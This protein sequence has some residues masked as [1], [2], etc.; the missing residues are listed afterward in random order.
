MKAK[1]IETIN[2][3]NSSLI[4]HSQF[5][6]F[7]HLNQVRKEMVDVNNVAVDLKSLQIETNDK[8]SLSSIQ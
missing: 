4:F 3:N 6:E 5:S 8:P 2:N 7:V 1:F